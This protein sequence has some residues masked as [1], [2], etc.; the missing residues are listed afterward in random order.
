MDLSKWLNDERLLANLIGIHV[1]LAVILI[2]SIILRKLLKNSGDHLTRWT[3]LQ[4]LE[5]ISR[6]AVKGLRS[7]LFW[8]TAA[9]AV[10]VSP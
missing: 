3:A 4:W 10:S 5:G 6:E 1:V 8:S 9:T 2:A 7:M